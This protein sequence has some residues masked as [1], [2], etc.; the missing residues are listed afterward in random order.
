MT[1]PLQSPIIIDGSLGEGGGQVLRSSLTLSILTR[2]PLHIHNIRLA[3]PKPGLQPQ[4][5]A[6]VQAAAAICSAEL[7]GAELGSRQVIFT[8]GAVRTGRYSFKIPTAGSASL[9]LQTIFLPL[10]LAGR[11]STVEIHGGTHV[12][13]SPPFHYLDQHWLACLKLAGYRARLTL[14]A[15]GFYPRGSGSLSAQLQ[16]A[17]QLRGLDLSDPG[18]LLRI[19][20]LSLVANLDDDIARRLK[21]QALRLLEPQVQDVKIQT[22]RLDG[23]HPGAI[24]LLWA[25]FE[26]SR[27]WVSALGAPGKRA[28][29]VASEAVASLETILRSG[30]ALDEHLPDQ[31]LLPLAF[32]ASPSRLSTARLSPH[33]LTNIQVLQAFLPTQIIVHGAP[34]QPGLIEI[35]PVT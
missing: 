5:L 30:A 14:D 20:G 28:E 2:R 22:G 33:L 6:A 24:L 16:S 27:A 12:P 10:A 3:R 35:I 8:P 4:H 34:G 32:A 15:A 13:W 1:D 31:L 21:L 17:D 18:A 9:V 11:S 7:R 19:R 29:I 23:P 26:H 25:E